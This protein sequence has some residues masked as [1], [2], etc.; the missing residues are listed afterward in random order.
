MFSTLYERVACDNPAA[1]FTASR[2]FASRLPSPQ[3]GGMP[4][5]WHNVAR[6]RGTGRLARSAARRGWQMRR[7][8]AR[9]PRRVRVS[10]AICVRR[11]AGEETV[12]FLPATCWRV[13]NRFGRTVTGRWHQPI[14]WSGSK[15]PC[16][17]FGRYVIYTQAEVEY[18]R[19]SISP[20]NCA[21]WLLHSVPQ[22][23]RHGSQRL[24]P[25]RGLWHGARSQAPKRLS[26]PLLAGGVCCRSPVI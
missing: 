20:R 1:D 10:Q 16:L 21:K 6:K 5:L 22:S 8:V 14:E 24:G 3:R 17:G 4:G 11:R 23:Q 13:L 15:R 9:R 18:T 26:T 7:P 2:L 12:S 19:P 25:G